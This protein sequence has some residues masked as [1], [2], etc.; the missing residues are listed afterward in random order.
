MYSPDVGFLDQ[1]KWSESSSTQQIPNIFQ[2]FYS[3][4]LVRDTWVVDFHA[5]VPKSQCIVRICVSQDVNPNSAQKM[6]TILRKTKIITSTI[7]WIFTDPYR[8]M[9]SNSL[10]HL[11]LHSILSHLLYFPVSYPRVPKTWQL[12]SVAIL[13]CSPNPPWR[14]NE[15]IPW[16]FPKEMISKP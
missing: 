1:N 11:V 3:F 8:A 6:D 12:C 5:W 7:P 16:S 13:I 14:I 4:N 10:D 15:N 9:I 2:P